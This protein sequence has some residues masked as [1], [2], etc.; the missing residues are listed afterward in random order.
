LDNDGG[1]T[2]E[3]ILECIDQKT[4]IALCGMISG[5]NETS[6]DGEVR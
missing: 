4:R 6:R 5:Y 1:D 3:A 2:P